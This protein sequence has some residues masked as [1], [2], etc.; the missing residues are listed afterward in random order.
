[1][2]WTFHAVLALSLA[3][4]CALFGT[5]TLL[6]HDTLTRSALQIRTQS[7]LS[8]QARQLSAQLEA[9]LL[10]RQRDLT[11]LSL[12]MRLEQQPLDQRGFLNSLQVAFPGYAWIGVTDASGRVRAAT[13]GLLEGQ[14]VSTRPWFQQ[15]RRGPWLGDV[16]EAK[17]LATLLPPALDGPRRF[18]D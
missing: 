14:D 18:V 9:G 1:M 5:A 8:S 2:H 15:G 10:E 4:T 3:G 17:L 7:A 6:L 12:L 16:H 13:G 11:Q